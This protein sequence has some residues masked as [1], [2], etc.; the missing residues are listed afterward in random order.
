MH[1]S[2]WYLGVAVAFSLNYAAA[3]GI[4]I[5]WNM[6]PIYSIPLFL[7]ISFIIS[8]LIAD[9]KNSLVYGIICL[10]DGMAIVIAIISGPPIVYSGSFAETQTI[11]ALTLNS[12][13]KILILNLP[14]FVAGLL[15]GLLLGER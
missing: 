10:I 11:F 5:I 1:R 13:V 3:F 6:N 14:S 4:P 9:L 8:A 15:I 12:V 7:V 2:L